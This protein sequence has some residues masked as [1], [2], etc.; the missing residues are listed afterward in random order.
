MVSTLPTK[1]TVLPMKFFS[2]G[3]PTLG[4]GWSTFM[5]ASK[6]LAAESAVLGRS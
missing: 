5:A 1:M 6:L 2:C 4:V 3:K